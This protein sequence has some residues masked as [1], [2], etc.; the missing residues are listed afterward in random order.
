[1]PPNI[2]REQLLQAFS[3]AGRD[4]SRV[5][6]MFRRAISES[7]KLNVTDGECLDFLLEAG[8]ATLSELTRMTG[9]SPSAMT[10]CIDRLERAGYVKRQSDTQDRR[11]VMVV[12]NMKSIG[13]AIKAYEIF[14]TAASKTLTP[15]SDEK[16][17]AITEYFT[18]MSGVYRGQIERLQAKDSHHSVGEPLDYQK[19]V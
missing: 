12:P 13:Q 8:S 19:G 5:S 1:M 6:L 18:S 15:L 3:V 16:L 17:V 4:Y 10:T 14:F 9:L 11:R 2:S 7:M